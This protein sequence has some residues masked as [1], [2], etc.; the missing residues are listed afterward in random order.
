MIQSIEEIA[1]I[2]DIEE[3][4]SIVESHPIIASFQTGE[5]GGDMYKSTYDTNYNN[6]VDTCE[7]IDCGTF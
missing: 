4:Y 6:I 3:N 1:K 7:F 5:G 2:T